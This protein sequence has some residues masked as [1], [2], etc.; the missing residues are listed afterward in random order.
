M[1]FAFDSTVRSFRRGYALEFLAVFYNN[2]R[3]VHLDTKHSDIRMNMEKKLCKNTISTLQELSCKGENKQ[4]VTNTDNKIGKEVKQRY[5]FLL[6]TLL[7]SIYT[8]QLSQAWNWND[9]G[10][11]LIKYKTNVSLAKDAKTAYNRLATQ[12]GIPVNV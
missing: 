3:L 1:D 6:L 2:G 9:I 5:V 8:Q 4:T 10:N 11:V 7:R 12:I